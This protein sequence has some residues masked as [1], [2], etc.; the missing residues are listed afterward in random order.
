MAIPRPP[1]PRRE[2]SAEGQRSDIR[3]PLKSGKRMRGPNARLLE[4]IGA[5][6]AEGSDHLPIR[7]EIEL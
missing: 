3:A 2:G 5:A 7:I 6:A 1:E 4:I